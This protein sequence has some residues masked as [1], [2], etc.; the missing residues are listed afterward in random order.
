M[1]SLNLF[2]LFHAPV[3]GRLSK[4]LHSVMKLEQILSDL[5]EILHK[6]FFFL[7]FLLQRNT[8]SAGDSISFKK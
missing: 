1:S 7:F 8:F 6:V 2:I 4:V 3:A 5:C